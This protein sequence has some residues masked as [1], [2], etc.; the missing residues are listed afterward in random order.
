MQATGARDTRLP[1]WLAQ[2]A[3]ISRRLQD[4]EERDRTGDS[5]GITAPETLL[6]M[7]ADITMVGPN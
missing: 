2:K 3:I 5:P 7:R 1:T 4:G 6:E